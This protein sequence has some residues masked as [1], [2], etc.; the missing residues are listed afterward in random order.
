MAISEKHLSSAIQKAQAMGIK[1]KELVCNELF[2]EQPNL[3]SSVVVQQMM[4]N[5]LEEID[6]LLNILIVL[7]LCIKE[8][9][10]K[11]SK[12]SEDEQEYQLKLFTSVVKFTEGMDS[13]LI[14]SSIDQYL[15]DHKERFLL[16]YVVKTMKGA[17]F[18]ENINENSKFLIMCG[19]NLV[20]CI[21]NAKSA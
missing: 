5:T 20:N 10:Q 9:G 19:I 15:A 18:F 7:H 6:V 2:I 8:S 14:G 4:G 11:I 1:E 21:V 13:Q 16:A 12:I 3:L 17:K